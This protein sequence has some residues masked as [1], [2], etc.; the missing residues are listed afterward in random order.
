MKVKLH[1]NMSGG[2]DPK[3]V[4]DATNWKRLSIVSSAALPGVRH[5]AR[6]VIE[7]GKGQGDHPTAD[8]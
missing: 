4:E 7:C 1:Q 3:I 5:V 6:F 2:A 8:R